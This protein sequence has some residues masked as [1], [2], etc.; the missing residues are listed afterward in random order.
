MARKKVVLDPR[1]D[2]LHDCVEL[3]KIEVRS[4]QEE[5]KKNTE[6]TEQVRDILGSFR[7]TLAAGRWLT[8]VGA[9]AVGLWHLIKFGRQ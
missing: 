8:A 6:V 2:H 9:G 4:L 5:M 7:F 3:V 1:I